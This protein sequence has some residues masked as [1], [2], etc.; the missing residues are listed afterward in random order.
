M[1]TIYILDIISIR[2]PDRELVFR[3]GI[4]GRGLE[5][6]MF[7]SRCEWGS[8]S[9]CHLSSRRSRAWGQNV[10]FIFGRIIPAI[11]FT[12]NCLR[13]EKPA[14]IVRVRRAGSGSERR[15]SGDLRGNKTVGSGRRVGFLCTVF[16]FFVIIFLVLS[17]V[18]R[19]FVPKICVDGRIIVFVR[20][21]T[22][23]IA[24]WEVAEN[25]TVF[26]DFPCTNIHNIVLVDPPIVPLSKRGPD[27][28]H[29]H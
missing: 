24:F 2:V 13:L 26:D 5:W 6:P 9:R 21:I 29:A 3:L 15:E 16:A 22:E 28:E 19:Y 25:P 20:K 4:R 12:S 7:R 18:T 23:I 1:S 10:E 27:T 8:P 11:E 14:Q 17:K